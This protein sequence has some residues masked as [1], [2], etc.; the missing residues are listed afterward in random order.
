MNRMVV[1]AWA[2]VCLGTVSHAVAAPR[3]RVSENKRFLVKEDGSPFFYLGDTAWEL[4]HRLNREGAEKYLT[5]RAEKRFTVIQAVV[6][7][8]LDGLKDPN[9]Y[10]QTPLIDNDPTKPNEKYFEHVDWVVNKAQELGLYVGMLPTWGDKFNKKWGVGPEVFTPENARVYG[11]WLGGRYKDK[12]I[13][14]VMGGD[15][16]IENDTHRAIINAMAEGLR[17]GD[18]GS[19]LIT[20]H[21]PGG[22]NSAKWFHGAAWLDFNMWQN[23]HADTVPAWERIA[24]D[25]NRTPVKPVMD[26]EPIYEDHPIGFKPKEFGYSSAADVRRLAYWDTFSG[27]HGHTYGN[28]SVWQMYDKGRNPING[29]VAPW[30]EV[31]DRPGASQMQF[32][33]NLLES[34]PFLTRIPD[35]TLVVTKHVAGT[36]AD[37]PTINPGAGLKRIVATRSSDGAY[38]M[39]YVPSSRPF[40]VEVGRI[41]GGKAKG[42]WYNPRNGKAEAIGEFEAKGR[43]E[44]TPPDLGEMVDWV[45]V[46]DDATKGFGPPGVV[47]K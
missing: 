18:G 33:R 4:F 38:A 21:P 26:G 46:L 41:S 43:R 12:A 42:W 24:Q 28:H 36:A 16:P 3:L 25:Y 31:L 8:E 17:E 47:G 2:V 7:A 13:I 40:E 15:R 6:L 11:R 37:R 34:R 29:P 35:P 10:G 20:F 9:P 19:H 30:H 45:L 5:N 27:A 14:W 23:G 1:V 22:Q 44:F 32:V 39:V